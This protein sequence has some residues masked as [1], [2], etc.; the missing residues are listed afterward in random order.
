VSEAR[1]AAGAQN[2]ALALTR[3]GVAL[4]ACCFGVTMAIMWIVAEF[5]HALDGTE[6]QSD[7]IPNYF[8]NLFELLFFISGSV[9]VVFSYFG[10]NMAV[11][12][13]REAE[14]ARLASIYTQIETRWSSGEM[15]RSRVAFRE[16]VSSYHAYVAGVAPGTGVQTVAEFFNDQLQN[17]SRANYRRYLSV[18]VVADYLEFIGM[19]EENLTW[20][21]T[22]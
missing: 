8:R 19:I 7:K 5:P 1:A 18:M 16:L 9:L 15:V 22:T 14:K 13:A 3:V 11:D 21:S 6:T 20:T 17:L 12:Q 4:L 2:R 10:F